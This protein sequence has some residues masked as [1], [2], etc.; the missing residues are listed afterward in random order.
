MTASAQKVSFGGD[1]EG[2]MYLPRS[3]APAGAVVI[4]HERYG[5][6]RHT[7]DLA[8]RLAQEGYVALAP[9]LFSRWQ[10]DHEALRRGTARVILPD[11]EVADVI[12]Q[13]LE[14]LKV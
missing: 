11:P 12:D 4:L 1:G 8:Q 2:F 13:A 6:V 3:E 10:G 9:N 5:L 7:L 14:F